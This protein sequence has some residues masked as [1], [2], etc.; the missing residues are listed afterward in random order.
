MRNKLT[1]L[2]SA[3]LLLVL[4]TVVFAQE[5]G[6]SLESIYNVGNVT[7][8]AG[9][10][11]GYSF[12]LVLYPGAEII[13]AQTVLGE[14]LP[15]DFGLAAKGMFTWGNESWG[16]YGYDYGYSYT[17][18][19]VGGFG[20][21]HLTFRGLEDLPISYLENMDFYAGL[22][23]AFFFYSWEW[24]GTVSDTVE[25]ESRGGLQF[26]SMGGANYWLNDN[27]AIMFEGNYMG[28]YGGATIGIVLKI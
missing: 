17:N 9:I 18:I 5:D 14:T 16:Y 8:S 15:M 10:G 22:G 27:L 7:A 20:T 24:T 21:A 13:L 25:P 11:F 6:I 19:G 23:L 12:D 28:Y 4:P 3:L 2:L 26:V 1:L